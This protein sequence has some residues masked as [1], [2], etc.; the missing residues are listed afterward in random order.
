MVCRFEA[1]VEA[2]PAAVSQLSVDVSRCQL[3][4]Q[5]RKCVSYSEA[6]FRADESFMELFE[7]IIK[8]FF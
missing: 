3:I 2:V 8:F 7:Q 4:C 5:N 1:A 6:I